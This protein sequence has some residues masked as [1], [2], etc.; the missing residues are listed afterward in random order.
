[1]SF[2]VQA[3]LDQMQAPP[4]HIFL[5]GKVEQVEH[6]NGWKARISYQPRAEF[7]NPMGHVQG[8]MLC[9]M[10][11][12]AMGLFAIIAQEGQP[13]ATV[14]MNVSFLRP[15]NIAP[16]E[17]EVYFVRQGRRISNIESVAYQNG[18][19]VGKASAAFTL[20]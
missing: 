2:D 1:M 7:A 12:D 14:T 17:V 5:G 8:G 20:V 13:S 4:I 11:D 16:V 9:S 18:K 15:C 19:E 6:E 3:F 10:L